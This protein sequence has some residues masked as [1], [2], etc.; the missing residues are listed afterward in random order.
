MHKGFLR[1]G[2]FFLALAVGL[3]AFATHSMKG[4][5]SDKAVETFQVGISYMLYHALGLVL[6]GILYKEFPFGLTRIA[7]WLFAMG[8]ILFSFSLFILSGLQAMVVPGYRWVGAITPIG[9]L[10]FIAGWVFLFI[11]TFKKR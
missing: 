5:V 1:S 11:T 9:G 2:F 8:I 6:V 3:G 7:G 4:L 10:C